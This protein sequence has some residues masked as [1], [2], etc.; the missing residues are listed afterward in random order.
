[1]F[2]I[3]AYIDSFAS[4]AQKPD[5]SRTTFCSRHRQGI[6][7]SATENHGLFLY[8]SLIWI[9]FV[10]VTQKNTENFVLGIFLSKP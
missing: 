1:M 3:T 2:Y 6:S 7:L 4:M 9:Y 8:D 5:R 10:V